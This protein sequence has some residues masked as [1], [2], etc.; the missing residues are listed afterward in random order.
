MVGV[1]RGGQ[2][3]ILIKGPEALEAS[4]RI[5]TVVLDKTGTVTSG[6]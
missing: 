4:G 2:L 6:R 3:G 1:G 5:D